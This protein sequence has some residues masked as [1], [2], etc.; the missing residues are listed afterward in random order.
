ML[1]KAPAEGK[2][3]EIID[4]IMLLK[5]PAEEKMH[6][7][8]RFS[9]RTSTFMMLISVRNFAISKVLGFGLYVQK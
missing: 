6:V 8:S 9:P 3:Q 2:M 1:L 4:Y 5:A 7:G